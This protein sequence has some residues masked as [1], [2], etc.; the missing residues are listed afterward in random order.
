MRST[1][2]AS[3][4]SNRASTWSARSRRA[5]PRPT[6]IRSRAKSSPRCSIDRLQPV[7]TA[8]RSARAAPAACPSGSCTSSTTTSRSA[9]VDLEI[10]RQPAD[11]LAA[12]VHERQRLGQQRRLGGPRP[13]AISASTGADFEPRRRHAARQLVDH[14]E[15]DVVPRA[16]VLR[17]RDCRARRSASFLFLLVALS[18]LRLVLVLLALLDDFGLGRRRRRRRGRRFRPS[19]PLP[20]PSA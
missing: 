20:R 5:S 1:S 19:P 17:R 6:P 14:R 7:V 9:G 2:A 10:A 11:R 18:V 8:G 16:A 12:Q 15:A 13:L 4:W 3:S